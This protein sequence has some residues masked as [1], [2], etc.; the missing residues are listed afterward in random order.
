MHFTNIDNFNLCSGRPR[1]G[2]SVNNKEKVREAMVKISR[3]GGNPPPLGQ[4]CQ[5]KWLDHRRVNN[6]MHIGYTWSTKL[7]Q[8]LSKVHSG[9]G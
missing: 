9:G 4:V 6:C 3:G 1:V 5:S 2:L 8:N 7:Q